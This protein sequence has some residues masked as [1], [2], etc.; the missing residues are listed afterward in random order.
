MR[1][2][3]GKD[4]YVPIL[5]RIWIM[6]LIITIAFVSVHTTSVTTRKHPSLNSESWLNPRV[7][8]IIWVTFYLALYPET[9]KILHEEISSI[10]Q[11]E[12]NADGSFVLDSSGIAKAVKT[13]SFIREVM[14]MKG[15][16]INVARLTMKDVELGG[17]RI[18]K[19]MRTLY[20]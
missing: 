11:E 2:Y 8:A 16:T 4:G 20:N 9:Q 10:V 18:P 13:D 5:S 1:R 19:G 7:A 14:R 12:E 17:Y 6:V 15:D 3:A